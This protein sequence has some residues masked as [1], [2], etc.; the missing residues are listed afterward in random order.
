MYIRHRFAEDHSCPG[1]PQVGVA[2]SS[3]SSKSESSFFGKIADFFTPSSS[4]S[5]AS[6]T[7]SVVTSARA[8]T[9]AASASA[10]SA[11]AAAASFPAPPAQPKPAAAAKPLPPHI[12]VMQLKA[13]A[14]GDAGIAESDRLWFEIRIP[15]AQLRATMRPTKAVPAAVCSRREMRKIRQQSV[16]VNWACRSA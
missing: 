13:R 16:G 7:S 15:S 4:P 11:S 2:A 8:P 9:S 10:A 5:S 3:S 14:V 12:R 1:T 6:S